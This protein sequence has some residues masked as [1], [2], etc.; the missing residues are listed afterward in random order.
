V[1]WIPPDA[2]PRGQEA[3]GIHGFGDVGQRC[4][5][6]PAGHDSCQNVIWALAWPTQACSGCPLGCEGFG[7]ALRND[8][9]RAP[10]LFSAAHRCY[11]RLRTR[12]FGRG[13]ELVVPGKGGL[14]P[15]LA[16]ATREDGMPSLWLAWT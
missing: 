7:D 4:A 14:V 10:A 5:A 15:G 1:G 3:V 8:F 13:R 12:D 16:G 9:R 6:C 2:A 11:C